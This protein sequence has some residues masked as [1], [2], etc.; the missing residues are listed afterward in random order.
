MD[1]ENLRKIFSSNLNYWLDRRGKTQADLYKKTGTTSAT[2]SDWCNAKKIPRTDKL[3]E[4]VAW[5]GI[6]LSDLLTVK[7][8]AH[9]ELS[10]VMF[11]INDDADFRSLILDI[12]SLDE[13]DFKKVADYVQLLKK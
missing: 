10:D 13:G 3:I 5:L 7:E 4:I 2:A 11:K 1:N 12:I 9:N 8:R 6:E